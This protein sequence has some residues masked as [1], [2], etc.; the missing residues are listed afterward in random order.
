MRNK[1]GL[2]AYSDRFG[3]SVAGLAGLLRTKFDGVYEAVRLLQEPV[4]SPSPSFPVSDAAPYDLAV[5]S[6]LLWALTTGDA[7]PLARWMSVR[8]A[9]HVSVLDTEDGIVLGEEKTAGDVSDAEAIGAYYTQD[10]GFLPDDNADRL[11]RAVCRN[12]HGES[13]V[14]VMP[15]GGETGAAQDGC[16]LREI[17][18]TYYSALG[19]D[20]TKYLAARAVQ[21]FLPGTPQVYYMGAMM[22]PDDMNLPK[23]T[24]VARDINRHYYTDAEIGANLLRPEVRALNALCRFRNSLDAFDG[25]FTYGYDDTYGVLSILWKGATGAARLDFDPRVIADKGEMGQ[26]EFDAQDDISWRSVATITWTDA[27]GEH[28]TNDLVARPPVVDA[29]ADSGTEVDGRI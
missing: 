7:A 16:T 9:D 8:P 22:T 1:V 25:T 5:P 23:K 11:V 15:A 21:F 29:P 3:G 10:T 4:P 12:T 24:G 6:L 19:C 13:T 20:D 2:I 17:D 28:K 18:S 27:T 14:V 26:G